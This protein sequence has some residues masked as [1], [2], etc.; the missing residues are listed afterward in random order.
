M[1]LILNQWFTT[2]IWKTYLDID[3]EPL[4]TY[5]YKL[6][7]TDPGNVVSNRHGWQTSSLLGIPLAH[8]DLLYKINQTLVE[9]HKQMGLKSNTPSIVTSHWYNINFPG[10]YNLKHIHPH[11]VFSGV[12]YLQVPEKNSGDITFY[13]DNMFKSYLPHYIIDDWNVMTSEH[14][15]YSP[16]KLM[17]LIFPSC[18]EHDVSENL[19]GQDRISFS[20]NTK[21]HYY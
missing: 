3:V 7:E 18:I 12:F 9:V 5:L 6:K 17:L 11:S 4:I 15:T 14:V 19:T 1:N 10:S 20:F 2:P 13:R 8:E 16:E 21:T